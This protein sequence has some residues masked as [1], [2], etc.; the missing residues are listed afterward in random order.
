MSATQ[1]TG[2]MPPSFAKWGVLAGCQSWV[3]T[4]SAPLLRGH[5]DL[6]VD[7]RDDLVAAGHAQAPGRIREIVLDVDDDERRP[8]AVALHAG[9][10][11]QAGRAVRRAADYP[12]RAV[13]STSGTGATVS[14]GTGGSTSS[15]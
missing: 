13:G 4:T 9:R 15:R 3:A 14:G 7:R 2:Q 1:W 12:I 11:A 8:G 10:V 6:A 5:R